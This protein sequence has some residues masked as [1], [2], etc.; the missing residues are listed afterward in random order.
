[1]NL[2][3]NARQAVQDA[4]PPRRVSLRTRHD[5]QN[6]RVRIEVADNGPGVPREI[7]ARVFDPFFT[8][9]P[10]GEGAG[11]GLA[12]ACGIVE[13]H[14]GAIAVES[15]PGEGAR[16]VIELPVDPPPARPSTPIGPPSGRA[17]RCGI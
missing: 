7:R 6:Q 17:S 2:V 10:D 8:T 11:R 9:K 15:S 1:V 14:G 3:T 4:A 5:A 13:G 12:L 16:F